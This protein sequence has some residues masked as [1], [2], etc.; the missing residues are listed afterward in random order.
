MAT[1]R[2]THSMGIISHRAATN[3]VSECCLTKAVLRPAGRH[4]LLK[5]AVGHVLASYTQQGFRSQ[6]N[7]KHATGLRVGESQMF[8]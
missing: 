4:K 1:R 2:Q 8:Y 6:D 7:D 3:A 5:G